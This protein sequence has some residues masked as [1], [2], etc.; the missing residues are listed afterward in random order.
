MTKY[1]V[2]LNPDEERIVE[3]Y[4]K[5]HGFGSIS[6]YLKHMLTFGDEIIQEIVSQMIDDYRKRGKEF[7]KE[8]GV[9]K[10]EVEN[11]IQTLNK[12]KK[13]YPERYLPTKF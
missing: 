11:V 9:S 1:Y 10:E 7:C 6:S 8:E 13:N 4:V 5:T 12:L 2:K 3:F